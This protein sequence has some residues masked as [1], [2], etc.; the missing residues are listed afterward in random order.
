MKVIHLELPRHFT[1][2]TKEYQV[3]VRRQI[4]KDGDT[5]RQLDINV[6][7][8]RWLLDLATPHNPTGCFDGL[9]S[10]STAVE[11]AQNLIKV[12]AHLQDI[13]LYYGLEIDL[14]G[15]RLKQAVRDSSKAM[16]C[17]IGNY[18]GNGLF[19]GFFQELDLKFHILEADVVSLGIDNQ[20]GVFWA[21]E[22]AVWMR[23]S[24]GRSHVCI[25]RHSYENFSLQHHLDELREN[26]FF[27][28]LIDSVVVHEEAL[29]S[30]MRGLVHFVKSG[31][32]HLLTNLML[33]EGNA[34]VTS[35]PL[36]ESTKEQSRQGISDYL[37]PDDYF[38]SIPVSRDRLVYS[39]AMIRNKCF[40]K[41]CTFCVQ[42]SKHLEDAFYL[43]EAELARTL[44]ACAELAGHG[45][46][47]VNFLDEAM[48]P[49]DLTIFC[50]GLLERKLKIRWVGRMIASVNMDE[51]TLQQMKEAG[52][53]EILF[54]METF[55][56]KAATDMGKITGRG[57]GIGGGIEAVNKLLQADIF[58]ILS[59]IYAFPTA[60]ENS[61]NHDLDVADQYSEQT[62]KI[63]FIF[64]RFALFHQSEVFKKPSAFGIIPEPK[65]PMNDLQY[66]FP[67]KS[68]RPDLNMGDP[69]LER[70]RVGLNESDYHRVRQV[71]GNEI[72]VMASQVDYSSVGL[73]WRSHRN[74]SLLHDLVLESEAGAPK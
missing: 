65:A 48:R 4:E 41:Q 54:G 11:V 52:C 33:R 34:G 5:F 40:Y 7:F 36:A 39:M 37:I 17:L 8:W 22:L 15:L 23:A 57:C 73:W 56:Q 9:A 70:L 50:G 18:Y 24:G 51:T 28:S 71:W 14:G 69:R 74:R 25:A 16:G 1:F 68:T 38:S 46:R 64:N 3:E 19:A 26:D 67:Y 35:I 59:L 27:F 61:L 47:M 63:V 42:I 44:A 60:S 21:L 6:E 72:L 53:T 45:V 10:A 29:P 55:D 20:E 66:C 2:T 62:D 13:A 32:R 58:L 12:R 30:S 49:R 31:E 43:P